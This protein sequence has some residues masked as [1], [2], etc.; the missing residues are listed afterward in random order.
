MRLD[1]AIV[2]VRSFAGDAEAGQA[3]HGLSL[4]QRRL[5]VLLDRPRSVAA[6]AALTRFEAA[7]FERELLALRKLGLVALLT[8]AHAAA[9]AHAA[10]TQ[11]AGAEGVAA[12]PR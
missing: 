11:G 3:S 2:C 10:S 5:L 7:R 8:P 1:P 4:A 9:L 6:F 12:Q